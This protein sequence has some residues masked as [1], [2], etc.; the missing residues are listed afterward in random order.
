MVSHTLLESRWRVTTAHDDPRALT[1][2]VVDR[3]EDRGGTRW[4]HA[5]IRWRHEGERLPI[6]RD[7]AFHEDEASAGVESVAREPQIHQGNCEAQTSVHRSDTCREGQRRT[8]NLGV[9]GAQRSRDRDGHSHAA[10]ERDLRGRAEDL[11]A[12][13]E[14][15][16][17]VEGLHAKLARELDARASGEVRVR[18]AAGDEE[19]ALRGERDA[20][21]VHA[22]NVGGREA[23][24]ADALAERQVGGV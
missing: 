12:V 10:V 2:D 18:V 23:L 16:R 21:M 3:E 20:G 4:V 13:D 15:E 22:G 5:T 24:V 14:H 1:R 11:R 19:V 17:R 9:G 6:T 8:L 7:A